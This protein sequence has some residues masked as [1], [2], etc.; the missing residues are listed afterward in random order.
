MDTLVP[1][2]PAKAGIQQ[3][4]EPAFFLET[5]FGASCGSSDFNMITEISDAVGECGR[6]FGRITARE[7]FRAQG[8]VTHTIPSHVVDGCQDRRGNRDRCLLGAVARFETEV[9]RSSHHRSC[10]VL[11]KP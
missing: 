1:L 7:V 3:E 4:L 6:G 11:W 2:T 5:G 10:A 9:R 8:L